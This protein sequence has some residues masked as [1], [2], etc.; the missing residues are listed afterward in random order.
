MNSSVQLQKRHR[1]YDLHSQI[2]TLLSRRREMLVLQSAVKQPYPLLSAQDR[3]N[4]AKR[5]EIVPL[6]TQL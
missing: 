6:G 5:K 2:K 3:V 4:T 1:D